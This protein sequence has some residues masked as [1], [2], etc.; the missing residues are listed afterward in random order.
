MGGLVSHRLADAIMLLVDSKAL[1]G[2][3]MRLVSI[4][5]SIYFIVMSGVQL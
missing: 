3:A 4:L 2:V 5:R 1:P